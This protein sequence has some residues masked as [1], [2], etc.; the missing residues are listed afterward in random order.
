MFKKR[1]VIFLAVSTCLFSSCISRLSRPAISGTILDYENKPIAGCRV[2]ETVTDANGKFYL[3]EIRYNKF[4]FPEIFMMEAP[5][6]HFSEN[7]KK[8]GY[9][10]YNIEG[11]NRF[12]G[13]QSKGA[14]ITIDTLYLK[15]INEVIKPEDY[16]YT[17]WKFAANKNLDTLYGTNA[18]FRLRNQVTNDMNF[19]GKIQDGLIYKFNSTR[20]PDS[21]WSAESYNL[22]TTYFVSLKPNGTYSGKKIR[23][24]QNPWKYRKEYDRT[25]RESY[26]IPSDSIDTKGTFILSKDKIVFDQAFNKAKNS[27]KIDSIDRD[28]IILTR[29]NN[30]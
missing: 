6:L 23:E 8:D 14:S 24:F 30:N 7:I 28:I 15:K 4:F 1:F 22:K 13:G 16:I 20:K 27:Y 25:Y 29:K 19:I 21:A 2:G 5:P 18:N 10:S 9:L 17:K 26:V 12:G 11:F 3:N